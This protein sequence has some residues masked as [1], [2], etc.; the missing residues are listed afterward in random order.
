MN[1]FASLLEK[2]KLWKDW[3]RRHTLFWVVYIVVIHSI[4]TYWLLDIWVTLRGTLSQMASAYLFL[5]LVL[6]IFFR[7]QYGRVLILITI[8]FFISF[9]INVFAQYIAQFSEKAELAP[10]TREFWGYAFHMTGIYA[11][12]IAMVTGSLKIFRYQYQKEKSNRNLAKENLNGELFLLKSQIHPH[13]LFNTLNNL[14]ALTLK[15]SDKSPEIVL[16]LSGLLHYI[17]KE[18]NVPQVWLSQEIN[19]LKNYI[20]LEQLRYKKEFN[21]SF[22]VKG[23]WENK[24]IA[25]LLFL[26]FVENAFKHGS[27]E[28]LAD[29]K[30]ILELSV[31]DKILT[32]FLQNTKN[33]ALPLYENQ[34]GG[35]GIKNVKK[36]LELIYPN[37]HWLNIL[38]EENTFTVELKIELEEVTDNEINITENREI[39]TDT[40]YLEKIIN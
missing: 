10:V 31:K 40:F 28:Q 39:I 24:K 22:D 9:L 12:F 23:N 3:V 32:F 1:L 26:S 4:F 35:I 29:S 15:K 21:L 36:R 25:P 2:D 37:Q 20:S 6:P 13:F 11:G 7:K 17:I 14:Y 19:L 8:W 33:A 34:V 30:I 38:P 18:C 27:A 5:Y 16:K